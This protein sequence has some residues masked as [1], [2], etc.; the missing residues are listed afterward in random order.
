VPSLPALRS[1]DDAPPD[2]RGRGWLD[3]LRYWTFAAHLLA[4]AALAISNGLLA[5]SVLL[6]PWRRGL[7]SAARAAA[8][9]LVP[10]GVYLLFLLVSVAFSYEPAVSVRRI[11]PGELFSVSTLLLALV[12]VRGERRVRLVVDGLILVAAALAA[13]GLAQYLGGY[14]DIHRRIRGPFSH[15]MTFAGVLL[16]ADVMLLT[17]LSFHGRRQRWRWVA[18]A[19]INL[20]VVGSLTRSAWVALAAAGVVLALVR[21]PRLLL[22]SL[23]AALLLVVLAPAAVRARVASIVDLDDP[24][25]YDRLCM[26]N[27]GLYMIA[28]RPLFGIGPDLVKSRYPIY[29][30]P[31][32]PRYSVPHLH[33][34]LLQ[35]T[36]ERGLLSLAAYLWMMIA[37]AV[38][39]ARRYRLEGGAHGRRADLYLGVALALLAFNLA[40][41]FEDNWGDTEVQRLMLWLLAVPFCLVLPE[42]Q[43]R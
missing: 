31:T 5:L 14:G 19:L 13:W 34:S 17:R 28:E 20:A 24:S 27:A 3:E 10:V 1:Y 16:L 40:G 25:N 12:L 18:L 41:L 15:Y 35:L 42:E 39:A 33:S 8:P 4:I 36:A 7:R 32:A 37:A 21:K 2:P 22:W 23:P 6:A 38:Q 29:R 30:H 9:L 11:R 26:A 43:E